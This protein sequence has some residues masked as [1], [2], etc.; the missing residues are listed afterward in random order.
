MKQQAPLPCCLQLQLM[1]ATLQLRRRLV[2]CFLYDQVKSR[3]LHLPDS[4]TR[5]RRWRS[6]AGN[7]AVKHR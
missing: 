7:Q 6:L 1:E 3:A 5:P 4:R 2:C